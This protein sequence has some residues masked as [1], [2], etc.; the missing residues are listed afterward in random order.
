MSG[1]ALVFQVKFD[2]EQG[3]DEQQKNDQ[4]PVTAFVHFLVKG[5]IPSV[6]HY[7][8]SYESNQKKSGEDQLSL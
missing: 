1:Q 3:G 4:N 6:H 8:S 2:R 7:R 5:R